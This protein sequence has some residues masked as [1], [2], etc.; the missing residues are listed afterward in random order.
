MG[1]SDGY[2]EGRLPVTSG[3]WL[4]ELPVMEKP[5][6]PRHSGFFEKHGSILKVYE[7]MK[8][9]RVVNRLVEVLKTAFEATP[10]KLAGLRRGWLRNPS[11]ES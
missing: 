9:D 6:T 10:E 11:S 5:W 2:Y 3:A 7:A 1:K 8:I 4:C